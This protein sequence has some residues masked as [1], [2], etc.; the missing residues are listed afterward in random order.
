MSLVRELR[1]QVPHGQKT[2]NGK[3]KQFCNKFNK[4]FRKK[5][6]PRSKISLKKIQGREWRVLRKVVDH[7]Q[8]MQG[9]RRRG[10]HQAGFFR[11]ASCRSGC[12]W[13]S[14]MGQGGWELGTRKGPREEG[15]Q[16]SKVERCEL[17]AALRVME[18]FI[19][20]F[21]LHI[22]LGKCGDF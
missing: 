20:H 15:M 3:R 9:F 8:S 13:A 5:K 6:W 22:F 2:K 17:M 1:S 16:A 21:Y 19:F 10:V 14:I 4:D 7:P 12:Q 11:R 18:Y